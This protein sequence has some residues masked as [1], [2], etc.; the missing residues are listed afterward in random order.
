MAAAIDPAEKATG[1]GA[2]A[3]TTFDKL[4]FKTLARVNHCLYI[5][6]IDFPT[7]ALIAEHNVGPGLVNAIGT[8]DTTAPQLPCQW[9]NDTTAIVA[10]T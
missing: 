6:Y 9:F 5:S 2:A 7:L 10:R 1:V 3:H 8:F 4:A